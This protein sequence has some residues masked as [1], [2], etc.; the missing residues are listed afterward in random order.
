MKILFTGASSFSGCWY[1]RRLAEAGHDVTAVL[2][3]P[4]AAYADDRRAARLAMLRPLCRCVFETAFSDDAFLKLAGSGFDLFAHH[5][6][7]VRNYKSP[8]FDVLAA[9]ANN[10]G[11]LREVLARLKA[12]ACQRILLTGTY[13][14]S[15]EGAG[16]TPHRAFSPYAL[17][18]HLTWH[19][20]DYFATIG[21]FHL[22]KFVMPNP[23]GPL[24]EPR[25]TT[26]LVEQWRA[27]KTPR[28][29]TPDYIRDNV[30]IE[31][32]SLCYAQF[33]AE[34]PATPGVSR[35]APSWYVE[36]V[37]DFARRFAREIGPRLKLATP[38]EFGV[39]TEFAEP[40]VR[41]NS[42]RPDAGALGFDEAGAWDRLADFYTQSVRATP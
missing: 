1:A 9:L 41:L 22:G 27:G 37:E 30:P 10:T 24:E 31:L 19:M 39:Q 29:N 7:D 20:F 5:A 26:W 15:G 36:R 35:S 32:L 16:E 2:R 23:F 28:V 18:K 6:A 8:D 14:E 38:L 3:G 17:S 11:R 21:G 40:R 42:N 4:E 34:L 33:A 12:G 25:F 13:F